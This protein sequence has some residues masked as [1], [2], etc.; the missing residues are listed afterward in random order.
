MAGPAPILYPG[1]IIEWHAT[2]EDINFLIEHMPS[3]FAV[4]GNHD[5]PNHSHGEIHRSAY[6]TLCRAGVL[7]DISD[8]RE[9][10]LAPNVHLYGCPFGRRPEDIPIRVSKFGHNVRILLIHAYVWAGNKCHPGAK[11]EDNIAEWAG[12]LLRRFD[13]GVFGDNHQAFGDRI[14]PVHIINPGVVIRRR[15]DERTIEPQIVTIRSDGTIQCANYPTNADVFIEA[16]AGVDAPFMDLNV[17]DFAE[18]LR[19]LGDCTLKF[20]DACRRF[21]QF[22]IKDDLVIRL[23]QQFLEINSDRPGR[24]QTSGIPPGGNPGKPVSGDRGA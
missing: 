24:D 11:P 2:P 18:C 10:Q 7:T 1:D 19:E 16:P 14:G 15:Y 4:R 17:D 5:L 21:A 8:G 23:M 9:V 22:N 20:R 13:I 6:E 12:R 3:G